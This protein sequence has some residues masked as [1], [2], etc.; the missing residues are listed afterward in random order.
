MILADE[1]IRRQALEP[2]QSFIVQAPA[3][4]GK[5]ELL[6]QR[7]LKLLGLANYPEEILAMTFTRKAA[8][9]MKERILSALTEAQTPTSRGGNEQGLVEPGGA[10]ASSKKPLQATSGGSPRP[11]ES[12]HKITWELAQKVL[13]QDRLREW[14]LMDNPARLRIVTIDSFCSSL[15]RRMPLLSRMGTN[16]D[17]QENAKNLYRETARIILSLTENETNPYGELVRNILRHIDNSK[18]DFIKRIV[19]LLEKRDQWMISFF[20]PRDNLETHP[21]NDSARQDLEQTMA[22]LIQSRM[23]E[24]QDLFCPEIQQKILQIANYSGRNIDNPSHPC[25]CL[26]NLLSFPDTTIDSLKIWKGLAHLFLTQ[27]KLPAYRKQANVKLGF[28]LGKNDEAK[29]MKNE[30]VQ[31]V[32]SLQENPTLLP[33]LARVKKLPRGHF[34]DSEWDLLKSTIRLLAEINKSL[35]KVFSSRQITDFTEISLSAIN[36]LIHRDENGQERPTDLLFYLDC[37]IHHFLVDEYQ[38]TSYKQEEL[39]R[40][41]TAEW[42]DEDSKTLFIVGDPKQ[43]IYRFRDA[44]V[45]LFIKIQKRGLGSLP[46]KTLSLESNFRS[47]K[48]LVD[49]VNACFQKIFPKHNDPCLLYTSPSPRDVEESRMPSSA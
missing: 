26:A 1:K 2:D 48:K 40:K 41:L 5:T 10:I 16:L 28:P 49:W 36:G 7:Y 23:G 42:S 44:E 17:I 29:K 34:T 35:K 27:D 15:T 46:L 4:S 45:G 24:L 21:L 37:K 33:A 6:I 20:D 13:E 47:Q 12:H 31:L 19:Q 9:E 18:E 25:A 14:Q 11:E 30:F 32:D 22:G 38:D 8:A 39:L 3:G 43:S